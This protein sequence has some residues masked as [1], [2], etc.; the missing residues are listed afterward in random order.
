MIREAIAWL[1]TPCSPEARWQGHLAAAIAL[2]QRAARCRVAWAGHVAQCHQAVRTSFDRCERHRTALILGSGLALEYPLAALAARFERVVLA[3]IVH[4][5]PLRQLA[6][7][8]PH[9]ELLACDLSTGLPIGDDV[10]WVVSCNLLSQLPLIPM[11]R[12]QRR[13]PE[14]DA[15][16]L[17]ACGR[18]IM[19]RHLDWLGAI[20]AV[21]CLIADAEQTVRDRNGRVVDHADYAAAFDLDRHAYATWEWRIAPPGELPAGLSAT[22]RM[23]ACHWPPLICEPG[24]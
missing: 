13:R 22:H 21:R 24:H 17:E 20:D 2:Q 12:M 1:L 4:L 10:D 15:A 6:R 18:D 23:T 3:D 7:R 8:H 19:A 16:T 9:V 14:T 5:W 11:R